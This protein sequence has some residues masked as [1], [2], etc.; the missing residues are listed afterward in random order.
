MPE[1]H[2]ASRSLPIVELGHLRPFT[3]YITAQVPII[4]IFLV[5]RRLFLVETRLGSIKCSHDIIN[6][7]VGGTRLNLLR[8]LLLLIH[9]W[10]GKVREK[11]RIVVLGLLRLLGHHSG[12]LGLLGG[13]V[14]VE[15][16]KV[17]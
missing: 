12:L 7:L 16:E 2:K 1:A 11:V 17:A 4:V 8:L 5:K 14:V 15:V 3:I 13:G 9:L 10:I 6:I